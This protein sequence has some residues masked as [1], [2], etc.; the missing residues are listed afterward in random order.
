VLP[1]RGVVDASARHTVNQAV[2]ND[3]AF[4]KMIFLTIPIEQ[5]HC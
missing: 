2:N 4:L 3:N 5:R 1:V